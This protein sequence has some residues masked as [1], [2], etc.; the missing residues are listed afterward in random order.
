VHSVIPDTSEAKE[1]LQFKAR[2][3]K[4]SETLSQKQKQKYNIFLCFLF[5][6]RNVILRHKNI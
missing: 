4:V 6:E 3:G 2:L 1:V 5:L